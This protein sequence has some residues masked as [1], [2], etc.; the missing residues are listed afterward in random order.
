MIR[1]KLRVAVSLLSLFLGLSTH[2]SDIDDPFPST[3]WAE[4]RAAYPARL[5]AACQAARA[6]IA[7]LSTTPASAGLSTSIT[8]AVC[9]CMP[10]RADGLLSHLASEEPDKQIS[11]ERRAAFGAGVFEQCSEAMSPPSFDLPSGDKGKIET[12]RAGLAGGCIASVIARELT[13]PGPER[14]LGDLTVDNKCNCFAPEMDRSL[15]MLVA[16]ANGN[17]ITNSAL[18]VAIQTPTQTCGARMIRGLAS[19]CGKIPDRTLAG[20]DQP[21]YCA[22]LSDGIL[23]LSDEDLVPQADFR[24]PGGTGRSRI[25]TSRF[26]EVDSACRARAMSSASPTSLR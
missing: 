23:S 9:E 4:M 17:A 6:R 22:C 15:R 7:E 3:T 14:T 25:L 8:Q 26:Q 11:P 21:V 19:L 10:N 1:S 18:F 16:S 20:V 5:A 2:A 13:P 24:P 12:V